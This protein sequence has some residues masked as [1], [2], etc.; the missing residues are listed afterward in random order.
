ML[1]FGEMAVGTALTQADPRVGIDLP[2]RLLVRAEGGRTR[3]GYRD[4][5]VLRRRSRG[6]PGAGEAERL[7]ERLAHEAAGGG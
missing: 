2:L 4:P 7:I 5:R 3:V 6:R 1:V